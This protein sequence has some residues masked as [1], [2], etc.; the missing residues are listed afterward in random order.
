MDVG[1]PP[2]RSDAFLPQ[3]SADSSSR[4]RS[5][6]ERA[7]DLSPRRPSLVPSGWMERPVCCAHQRDRRAHLPLRRE[8]CGGASSARPILHVLARIHGLDAGARVGGQC[9]RPLRLLGADESRLLS[10]HRFRARPRERAIGGA[11]SPGRDG[12]GRTGAAG[13]MAVAR[14]DRGEFRAFG[15]AGASGAHPR[16]SALPMGTGVAPSGRLH[17]IG[18]V[19]VPLLAPECDGSAHT[20]ERLFA[21]GDNG[22]SRRVCARASPRDHG[23]DGG[24][25][26]RDHP[27]WGDDNG[28]GRSAGL[29]TGRGQT[30]AG[31]FNGERTGTTDAVAGYRHGVGRH[32]SRGRLAGPCTLQSGAVFDRRHPRP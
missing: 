11:A 27:Y 28:C 16:P 26:C 5:L 4:G 21:F 13:R 19:P 2:F 20:G 15:A 32:R 25:E 8:V 12:A 29:A 30:R 17:Q 7:V 22:E 23:R 14:R 24:L 10:T 1:A 3:H 6:S 9:H 18:S 31:L